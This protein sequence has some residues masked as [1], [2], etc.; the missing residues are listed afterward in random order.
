[1]SSLIFLVTFFLSVWLTQYI[2][3]YALKNNIFDTPNERSSHL[4]PIPRGGG[5]A[6]V[7]SFYFALLMLFAQNHIEFNIFL[8]LLG[9]SSIAI[10][11]FFDDKQHIS[12]PYRLLVHFS[13]A[14]WLCFCLGIVPLSLSESWI[15]IA[16]LWF[17]T[18]LYL[19]WLLNLYNFMDGIDGI[20][21]VEALTVLISAIVLLLID[22]QSKHIE[23]LLAFIAAL[24]GF[25]FFNWPPAKIFMGDVGSAFIGIILGGFSLIT[26]NDGSLNFV[27]WLI[28]LAV[29]IVDATYTLLVRLLRGEKICEAHC[30]HSYQIIAR[31]Y[32]HRRVTLGVLIINI[33]WLLPLA[34]LGQTYKN[35]LIIMLI[36]AY[37]PLILLAIKYRAGYHV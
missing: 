35:W 27:L 26:T 32:G 23:L 6:I 37:L 15:I 5:L 19:V 9:A 36:I 30:S 33:C 29:F 18:S 24:S 2:R 34:Y 22:E 14:V 28:L 11:G 4:I 12:A 17:G 1:M 8:G 21:T 3:Q 7:L 25:L 13:A 16:L 31:L 20:A 10:I